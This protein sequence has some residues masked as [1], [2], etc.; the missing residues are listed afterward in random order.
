MSI[1]SYMLNFATVQVTELCLGKAN[2]GSDSF[3][4]SIVSCFI[5]F[6]ALFVLL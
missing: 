1:S 6:P 3:M 2:I 5:N 4:F